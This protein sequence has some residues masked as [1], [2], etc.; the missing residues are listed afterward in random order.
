MTWLIIAIGFG[1]AVG[2]MFQNSM[3]DGSRIRSTSRIMRNPVTWIALFVLV[4]ILVHAN[5]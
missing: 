1:A 2:G 4:S 5:Q 3:Y